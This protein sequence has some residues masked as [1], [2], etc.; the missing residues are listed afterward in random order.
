[1][2]TIP[3]TTLVQVMSSSVGFDPLLIQLSN[4]CL[5]LVSSAITSI[6][7]LCLT[8]VTLLSRCMQT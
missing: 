5:S 6:S 3:C 4:L 2:I 1:M 7:N 8:G